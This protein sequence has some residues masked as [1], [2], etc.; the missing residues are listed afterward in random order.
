MDEPTGAPS[1]AGDD[2]AR[3]LIALR[4]GDEQAFAGLV[5]RYHKSMV[6]VARSYV[7]TKEVA[8]DVVQDAWLGIIQGLD[9]FEGRSSLRTWMFRIVIN[10]ATTRGGREARSVPFSSLGPDEPSVDPD[11]FHQSGR[12]AGWWLSED[13]VALGPDR[14]ALSRETRA[15]IDAVI[16]PL[17]AN[18]RVV[19]TLRDVQGFSAEEACEVLGVTEVNQRVLLH[20]A[21]TRVRSALEA[22]VHGDVGAAP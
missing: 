6:R 3:L 8:E 5:D 9:R 17:P 10:K 22:Y 1:P 12:W 11:R 14:V 16:A 15:M 4:S 2:E 7:A 20:R 21:R 19:I 13:A 18:Q